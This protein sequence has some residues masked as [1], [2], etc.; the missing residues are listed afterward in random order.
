MVVILLVD[1]GGVGLMYGLEDL[2]SWYILWIVMG[3]GVLKGVD[4]M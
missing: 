2:C 4:L 1:Y 3:L